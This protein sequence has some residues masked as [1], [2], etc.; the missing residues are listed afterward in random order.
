[1]N[2]TSTGEAGVSDAP[3]L[4]ADANRC[5]GCAAE[6][7]GAAV[8]PECGLALRG[9]AAATLW[10]VTREMARLD[11][12]RIALLAALRA[13]S[14]GATTG[15]AT[16]AETAAPQQAQPYYAPMSPAPWAAPAW[17]PPPRRE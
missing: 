17:T 5:P 7:H 11:G 15:A 16:G 13:Q 6:L 1:M 14:P 9:P 8:C 3:L 10:A 2:E 12:H 4:V